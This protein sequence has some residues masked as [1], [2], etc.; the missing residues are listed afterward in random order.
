MSIFVVANN[1]NTTLAAPVTTGAT[2]ITLSSSA[3]LPTLAAGQIMA[4]TIN[5]E[6]TR[7]LES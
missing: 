3:N 6:A 1:V 7:L 2:S 5:D 4:I